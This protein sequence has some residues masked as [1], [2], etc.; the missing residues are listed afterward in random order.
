MKKV[1]RFAL[2]LMLAATMAVGLTACGENGGDT[3]NPATTEP[4]T[5]EPVESEVAEIVGDYSIDLSAL[6]MPLTVYLRI[7]EDGAF[8]FSNSTEFAVDK[9]SGTVRASSDGYIMVYSTIN[10]EAASGKTTTLKTEADG[11][12]KF[13]GTVYYGSTKPNSPMENEDTGE[14]NY[15]YAVPVGQGGSE[16]PEV[17][18]EKGLYTGTYESAGMGSA[19][20]YEYYLNLREDGKFTAFV[21]FD[22]MGGTMFAYDYGTYTMMGSVCRMTSEV[23]T[24]AEDDTKDLTESVMAE[25]ET[26]ITA[27]VK[28]SPM[29]KDTVEITIVKAEDAPVV[30]TYVASKASMM[31]GSYD[32]TLSICADGSYSYVSKDAASGE[33]VM[34]ESGFLGLSLMGTS[35]LLP[36]GVTEGLEGG[37]DM[38]TDSISGLKFSMVEGT[39]R[40]ELAFS[41]A[42]E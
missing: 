38:D 25:S 31:G 23:Y 18:L 28:M 1:W 19:V 42:A 29:A 22:M 24:E 8:Q 32:M 2:A 41:R 12:L 30:A 40:T 3:T 27:E 39:P 9:N 36:D 37:Y 11:R 17:V 10:G 35:Y 7:E 4:V 15:L 34:E 20:V 6:G 13:E 5:T 21:T 16:V 26:Q 33:V 14:T